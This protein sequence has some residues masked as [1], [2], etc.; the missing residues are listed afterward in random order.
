MILFGGIS[1]DILSNKVYL[2]RLNL[3]AV[4]DDDLFVVKQWNPV[5]IKGSLPLPRKSHSFDLLPGKGLGVV[6]G[7]ITTDNQYLGD[8]WILD[9]YGL[10]W[11]QI[12]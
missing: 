10:N 5:A 6:M 8:L 2:L 3:S 11:I 1:E 12:S 4:H 9:L 7:G